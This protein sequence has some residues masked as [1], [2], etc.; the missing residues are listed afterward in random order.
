MNSTIATQKHKINDHVMYLNSGICHIDDIKTESFG[1]M[2]A[3]TYFVIHALSD[4]RSV[5]FVPVD[6]EKLTSSM[7][8]LLTADEIEQAILHAKEE[9]LEWITDNKLRSARYMELLGSGNRVD[10]LRVLN[11]ILMHKRQT[12]SQKKKF[13]AS[14][15]RV[16]NIAT[17]LIT[18]ELSFVLGIPQSE[19]LSYISKQANV[20]E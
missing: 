5:I 3:R 14:D 1:G 8:T 10:T 12:E 6:S 2:E 20:G 13:Y 4:P 18:E 7:L 16:L 15:E 19:V 17:R 9:K 11:V